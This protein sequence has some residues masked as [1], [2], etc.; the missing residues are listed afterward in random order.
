[1]YQPD[2]DGVTDLQPVK[3][4]GSLGEVA[5][6][7]VKV[8]TK[9]FHRLRIVDQESNRNFSEARNTRVAISG[10]K[11]FKCLPGNVA[12]HVVPDQD[13]TL[14]NKLVCMIKSDNQQHSLV[15]AV[16]SFFQLLVKQALVIGMAMQRGF[17]GFFPR[18]LV[19]LVGLDNSLAQF[20]LVEGFLPD[21]IRDTGL[22]CPDCDLLVAGAGEHDGGREQGVFTILPVNIQSGDTVDAEKI[23]KQQHIVA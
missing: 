16:F 15:G 2:T 23:I 4:V 10:M 18:S 12:H 1:M 21:V 19:F 6:Q 3:S 7:A 22:Q 8:K 5:T 20:F 13:A 11:H 17:V 14:F 9:G